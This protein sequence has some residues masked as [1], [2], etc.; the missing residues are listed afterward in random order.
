[1]TTTAEYIEGADGKADRELR[2]RMVKWAKRL[3]PFLP[4]DASPVPY[5]IALSDAARQSPDLYACATPSL[6]GGLVRTVQTGLRLGV[7]CFIVP[8]KNKKGGNRIPIATWVAHYKGLMELAYDSGLVASIHADVVRDGDKF[9]VQSGDRPAIIHLHGNPFEERRILG[10]YA[11]AKMTRGGPSLQAV[12]GRQYID[13]LRQEFS[14]QW[15]TQKFADVPAWYA[16]KTAI[17]QLCNQQLPLSRELRLAVAYD[18]GSALLKW[19][20]A[21]AVEAVS[22][23]ARATVP[24]PARLTAPRPGAYPTPIDCE[25]IDAARVAAT[26]GIVF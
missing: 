15:N 1:M 10:A 24:A 9:T 8:F 26:G 21:Q 20:E 18:Q 12:L 4:P 13:S 17:R 2:E 11:V 23:G 6:V 22:G 25:A 19:D 3:V 16:K 14:A 5:F 7:T